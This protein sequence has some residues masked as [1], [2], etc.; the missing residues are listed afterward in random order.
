MEWFKTGYKQWSTMAVIIAVITSIPALGYGMADHQGHGTEIIATPKVRT[1]LSLD[2]GFRS[3]DLDWSIAGDADGNA[4]NILSELTWENIKSQQLRL[5][6]TVDVQQ[7]FVIRAAIGYGS[8]YEGQNQ[9]SDYGGDNR[10]LEFSRSNNNSDDGRVW[11]VSIGIGPRLDFGLNFFSLVPMVGYSYHVQSLTMTD[12]YQT[13]PNTGAISGLDSSYETRW[14][15]PWMGVKMTI[16]AMQPLWLFQDVAF[17]FSFE[18]HWADYEAE[19]DWNLR[20]DFEHP[21]S[22]EHDADGFGLDYALGATFFL[23]DQFSFTL[24]Y[25][26]S[27]W[28]TEEGV[29]RV[30]FSDGTIGGTQL[31]RVRWTT[32]AWSLGVAYQ[33]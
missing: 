22:F 15:G 8:I 26:F 20:P 3:D 23:S 1:S 5:T 7:R 6:G 17:H 4:P 32:R 28:Q 14:Q 2:A 11:D 30:F 13:I 12:G 10:T 16:D 33:F 9:D 18:Y 27:E 21:K 25:E 19:A 24:A 29:D 31:N